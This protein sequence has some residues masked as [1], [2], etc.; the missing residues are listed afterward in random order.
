[1]KKNPTVILTITLAF[2]RS[3]CSFISK[4]EKHRTQTKDISEQTWEG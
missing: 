2:I 3:P 1:M 4:V